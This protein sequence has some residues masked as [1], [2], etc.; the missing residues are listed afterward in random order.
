MELRVAESEPFGDGL[1]E[2]IEM[3]DEEV[4][5]VFDKDEFIFAG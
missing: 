1:I 4:V 5:G 2:L 3:T